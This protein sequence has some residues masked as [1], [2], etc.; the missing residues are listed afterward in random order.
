MTFGMSSR[1]IAQARQGG[2]QPR[3]LDRSVTGAAS[4]I[5]AAVARRFV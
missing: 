5:G 1:T 2:M 4:G 3:L